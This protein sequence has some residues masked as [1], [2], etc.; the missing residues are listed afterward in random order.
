MIR[1]M[2]K[3]QHIDHYGAKLREQL[4][5]AFKEAQVQSMSVARE[6]ESALQ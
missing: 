2:K 3:Q 4:W 1:G 6:T 5:E